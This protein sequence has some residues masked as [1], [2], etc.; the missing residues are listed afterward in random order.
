MIDAKKLKDVA[1]GTAVVLAGMAVG[2]GSDATTPT[3]GGVTISTVA[4][5]PPVILDST[6]TQCTEPHT[7]CMT[8][9]MPDPLVMGP[10]THLAVGFYKQVP[11]MTPAEARGVLQAPPLQAGQV[12]RLKSPDG[13]LTGSFYPVI[14]LYMQGGGDIIA[15]DNLDYTACDSTTSGACE[16]AVT[17][18]FT[19]QA[20]NVTDTLKLVYG[21]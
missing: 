19:G 13:N 12:F 2:C 7:V 20:I 21:L 4:M 10:A 16:N 8:G 5:D 11:V 9:Q 1:W 17:Y 3:D 6:S 14:L 18:P 15:V